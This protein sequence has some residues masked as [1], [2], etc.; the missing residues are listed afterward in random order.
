[1]EPLF[2]QVRFCE[3]PVLATKNMKTPVQLAQKG[4][5]LLTAILTLTILSALCATSLYITSQN[6]NSTSQA[7][8]WQA[9]L[10]G[11]ESGVEQAYYALNKSQWTGW[12]TV[13]GSP[14]GSQPTGGT[15][16]TT[17]PTG[18]NYAYS[19]RTM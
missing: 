18:G 17:K 3:T 2:T 11:A 1:M 14:P 13:S 4:S 10:S 19:T 9:A 5:V 6:T 8:S 12:K 7:A 16:T 15:T